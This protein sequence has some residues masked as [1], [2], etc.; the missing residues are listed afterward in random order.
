MDPSTN[1]VG[2]ACSLPLLYASYHLI[3]NVLDDHFIRKYTVLADLDTL[4]HPRSDDKRI[5]GTA[6]VCGGR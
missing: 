1:L 6:V 5:K 2:A 3:G 4:A